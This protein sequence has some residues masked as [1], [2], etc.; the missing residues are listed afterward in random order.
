MP[1]VKGLSDGDKSLLKSSQT[2]KSNFGQGADYARIYVYDY[3]DESLVTTFDA[4]FSAFRFEGS[5]I[6]I[7]IGQHLRS[8]GITDGEYRVVYYFYRALAGS[9][10]TI[11]ERGITYPNKYFLS[12][13]SKDRTEVEI[14]PSSEIN[15]FGYQNGLGAVNGFKLFQNV[16]NV[17]VQW[18]FSNPDQNEGQ[19]LSLAIADNEPGFTKDMTNGTITIPKVYEVEEVILPTGLTADPNFDKDLISY[20]ENPTDIPPTEQGGAPPQPASPYLHT[21][22]KKYIWTRFN[23]PLSSEKAT[24]EYSDPN[25]VAPFYGWKEDETY[26][27]STKTIRT[28]RDFVATIRKVLGKTQLLLSKD[29]QQG[30]EEIESESTG[31]FPK[32]TNSWSS[33]VSYKNGYITYSENRVDNLTTYLMVEDEAYLI[34]NEFTDSQGFIGIKL[35]EPL[36]EN[37]EDSSLGYF[38]NEVLESVEDN[39]KLV[40]F[41]KNLD[42]ENSTFLRLPNLGSTDSPIEFRGTNF[43]N[44][45]TLVGSNTDVIQDIEDKLVSGSLLDVKVNVDYQKRTTELHD[46]DDNAFGNFINFSSAKERL[47]NFKYKLGLIEFYTMSQSQFTNVSSSTEKQEFYETKIDQVKNSFDHYESFLYN[48]SSSYVSSSAGQFHDT[49]WPKENSTSPY[50]LVPSTG[51]VAVT[52]YDNMIESASLYDTMNDNRLV[53]NLP[54][55]IK[56]DGEGNTFIEF[57]D[58]IGQQFDETWVYLKHFT[59]INDRQ[60]KFS[61]GISKD[62]VKHVAKASGLEVV[63]GNDLLNLSE[64]LLGKNIDDGSQTYE[65][66]QEEVTE[67]IWKRILANLPYLQRTKGTTRAVKGL[68]NCYGIPSTI[69]RV[70]EFGGPDY[71]DRVSTDLQRRFT[72]ALDFKGSQY[73][74]HQWTTDNLSGKVPET[75]EFRFRTP[76]RQNQTIIQKGN[77][78]AIS[79]LDGGVTNKG[80][81]KFQL[82]GSSDKF[83]ITSSTQQFYN[84]EMW[85]VMLTRRSASG[86]DLSDDNVSRDVTYELVTKQYD[87][88]RL[89]INYETSSSFSTSSIDLNG[90]FTSSTAVYIGGKGTTFDGNNFSGSIMEYRL[91]TEPLSQSKFNNHVKTSKAYNGNT[92][93]SHADNLV[94]RLTFDDNVD[95]SGSAGVRFVSNSVDNTT[96]A[97]R[98]GSQN[99][100]TDNFYRSISEVEEMTIP[101]IGAIRRNS[102]KIRIEDSFLT[103]SLSPNTTLQE[104]S[105]DFAPVDSNKLGVYFSPTDIV[106]KDIIYSLADV[107]YDDYIGDP[108]DQFEQDYRG[109]KDIQ[110][111]YWKKYPKSNN[112]WDYLRILKYYDSGIFKQIKSLLPARAKTTLGV[113]VEPNIL[114]RSKEVLGQIPTFESNYYENAG[115]YDQGVLATRII[116]GSDDNFLTVVGE[117]PYYEGES[118]IARWIPKSGSIGTLAMPSRYSLNVTQ[119][120]EWGTNYV[121]ASITDGDIKFE[122]VVNPVI[123]ASRLSEHNF[124]YR[125]YFDSAFSASLHPTFGVNPIHIGALSGSTLT[126]QRYRLGHR[127]FIGHYSH[128]FERSEIQSVA[129]DSTLFRSF[130]QATSHGADKNDPN[131]PAVEITLTN[132]TRLVT[133]EPGESRLVDDTKANPRT[134]DFFKDSKSGEQEKLD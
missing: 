126:Y 107:N 9:D 50:T 19:I 6:D 103:G 129:Y 114:N 134:T 62:I 102:N 35:Y 74:E 109:L 17:N 97:A 83:F 60:A 79:L 52:W 88:T 110:E 27:S 46:Y 24:S 75:I 91:W 87:A 64:Y 123:T 12:S 77:E 111:S 54:G 56:F 51:S 7:N 81:L 42:L 96:Y 61:E 57:V 101:N 94:Y 45:N 82:S 118:N 113:L 5:S 47:K 43:K 105:F 132:P 115:Q 127:A 2:T 31:E 66:A 73:I 72:Y 29:W 65:K 49:S 69:L 21:D 20:S 121:D 3:K 100:F 1:D 133:V 23:E 124:E 30:K 112:F 13:I 119:S 55:H 122:E 10:G 67:E 22:G 98:T 125:Y 99:S 108:R 14:R 8:N 68:L 15:L 90:A 95:L 89:K 80:K 28:K 130:Y 84:D 86:A 93:S 128:S 26:V 116:S 44:Y 117:F 120:T 16:P 48:E 39:I 33:K 59:D 63:N 70:R 92:T 18:T 58:M 106:D 41:D 11:T 131:Y 71:N 34:T 38:V 37:I 85:S 36:S 78:W 25:I 104:S 4:P 53:N 40:P 76:K 32:V